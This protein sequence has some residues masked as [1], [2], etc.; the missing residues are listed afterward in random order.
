[1]KNIF[2]IGDSIRLGYQPYVKEKLEGR[3]KVIGVNDNCRFTYYTLRHLLDWSREVNPETID[4]VHWNNGLWDVLRILGDEP[5]VPVDVYG[6]TLKRIYNQIRTIFPRAKIVFAL[7]TP[8]DETNIGTDGEY[9]RRNADIEAYNREASEVMSE[10]GVQVSDLYTFAKENIDT[11]RADWTHFNEEGSA[12][13]ADA[14]IKGMG[15]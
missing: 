13:L 9:A 1:M 2:L 4:I 12:L 7:T 6:A 10:L 5:L 15:L 11:L 8:V 14:V 3:A